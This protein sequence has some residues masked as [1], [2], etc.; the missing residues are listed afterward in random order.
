MGRPK[1]S[2]N[3]NSTIGVVSRGKKKSTY[4]KYVPRSEDL[5]P[6]E[7]PEKFKEY[8]S[9]LEPYGLLLHAIAK[10]EEED[11]KYILGV[12]KKDKKTF[13]YRCIWTAGTWPLPEKLQFEEF[14]NSEAF[15]E[16]KAKGIVN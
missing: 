12:I 7:V 8:A 13:R 3:S 15:K 4:K 11:G 9:R 16:H 1:K 5:P 14:F 2:L 6:P 10:S